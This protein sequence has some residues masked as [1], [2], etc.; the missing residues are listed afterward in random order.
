[1]QVQVK[2]MIDLQSLDDSAFA[3]L[4]ERVEAEYNRREDL[5]VA[6]AVAAIP[7]EVRQ[8]N[9]RLERLHAGQSLKV[10]QYDYVRGVAVALHGHSIGS[11]YFESG[12]YRHGDGYA[13]EAFKGPPY[14]G[15][16]AL[17]HLTLQP[18]RYQI[19]LY[20]PRVIRL[21]AAR[22]QSAIEA[23]HSAALADG[24][25][26]AWTGYEDGTPVPAGAVKGKVRR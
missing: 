25:P 19:P 11:Y 13:L 5:R 15:Y 4:R 9:L 17:V 18:W 8:V 12:H 21:L 24:Q 6:A 22:I 3:E 10:R 2:L 14:C 23:I 16:S 7:I 26:I 1:M 20:S